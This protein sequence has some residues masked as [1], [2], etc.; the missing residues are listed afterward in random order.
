MARPRKPARR[1]VSRTAASIDLGTLPR[2]IGY[3]LR[4]AQVAIFQHII[5]AMASLDVRPGQFSVLI[6]TGANPGIK[7][8]AISEALGIRRA[9]LVAMV[10]ELERRGWVRRAAVAG[11]RR[12]QGL[13]LTGKGRT[14][15]SRLK[16]QAA[17]HE[18]TVTRTITPREKRDLMRLLARISEAS[19]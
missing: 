4:R 19:T 1:A 17:S 12:A 9:N 2:H 15:L 8:T 10:N 5:R 14:A 13:R 18:R 11:D 7:Q 3:V 16:A 6:V